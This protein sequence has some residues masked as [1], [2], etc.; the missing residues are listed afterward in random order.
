[1]S[2]Q[3]LYLFDRDGSLELATPWGHAYPQL[4]SSLHSEPDWVDVLG[5][6]GWQLISVEAVRRDQRSDS[7]RIYGVVTERRLIFQRAT[8]TAHEQQRAEA[9]AM[10]AQ[11]EQAAKAA[12]ERAKA[13]ALAASE[14]QTRATAAALER[15]VAEARAAAEKAG[16]PYPSLSGNNHSCPKCGTVVTAQGKGHVVCRECRHVFPIG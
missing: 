6:D 4:D 16:L 10:Q 11:A 5:D 9:R 7:A 14:A 12:A 13:V 3:H 8:T 1:M 2:W 15:A